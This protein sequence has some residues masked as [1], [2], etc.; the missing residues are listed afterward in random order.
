MHDRR[1]HVAALDAQYQGSQDR[2]IRRPQRRVRRAPQGAHCPLKP[3]RSEGSK[4][5]LSPTVLTSLAWPASRA[6]PLSQPWMLRM[7]RCIPSLRRRQ[8]PLSRERRGEPLVRRDGWW[9]ARRRQGSARPAASSPS[10][11]PSIFP[12]PFSGGAPPSLPSRSNGLRRPRSLRPRPPPPAPKPPTSDRFQIA[13]SLSLP[14]P[15]P[16]WGCVLL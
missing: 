1:A 5:D 4:R 11:I 12:R 13:L 10:A 6:S 15:R 3:S 7:R 14:L 2:I 9:R 8:C 16:P